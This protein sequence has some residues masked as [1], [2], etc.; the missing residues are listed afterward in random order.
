MKKMMLIIILVSIVL[1]AGCRG[2][3]CSDDTLGY[4][5]VLIYEN[6]FRNEE[7][8]SD[9]VMEG[10]GQSVWQDGKMILIPDAQK[11]IYD[12][13]EQLGR[14]NMAVKSEYYPVIRDVIEKNNPDLL[15]KL[16]GKSGNFAGGHIV[17]WNNKI[18]TGQDY[19]IEYDFKPLSPIGLGIVFFSA[20]GSQ[21]QDILERQLK[22][23]YGVF[24]SYTHG[25]FNCYHISY[26]ANWAPG[27]RRTCNLRKNAGF[28]CLANG[29]DIMSADLD[30]SK[31]NFEYKNYKVQLVKKG[32]NIKFYIDGELIIDFTD[33]RFNTI[34]DDDGN[35][36]GRQVDTGEYLKGG[37]IGLR[38]MADLAA[39]YSNFKVYDIK[40]Q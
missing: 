18:S 26:W 12:S 24:D 6:K 13:W 1:F 36:V 37:R 14:R 11:A 31:G 40:P 21:G 2:L 30:Y 33:N 17:C 15:G 9:W 25:D 8:L 28:Y 3:E 29:A 38:Q 16:N 27:A 32:A 4:S 20:A 22:P 39:E 34:I 7:S 23:R 5:K 19:I 35:I 10:P